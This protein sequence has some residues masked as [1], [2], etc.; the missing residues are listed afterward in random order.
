MFK[1]YPI[2]FIITVFAA[3]LLN[4]CTSMQSGVASRNKEVFSLAIKAIN[5]RNFGALDGLIDKNYV[6]HCQATPEVNVRSLEEFKQFLES[7]TTAIPDSKM[8]IDHLVAEGDLVAFYCTYE[9][10]Q[11]GQMGLFPPSNKYAVLEFAGIHRMANGKIAES[12]LTWDNVAF[13]TQLGHFPTFP[14]PEGK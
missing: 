9:G 3:M 1:H 13:L 6:R 5:E 11:T 10:T 2:L 14:S 8:T 12:W 7:D 4:S